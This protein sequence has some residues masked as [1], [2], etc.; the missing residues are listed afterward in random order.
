MKR[1]ASHAFFPIL[2][3]VLAAFSAPHQ[4]MARVGLVEAKLRSEPSGPEFGVLQ[5]GA[6]VEIL[7]TQENW[8][9]VRVTGWVYRPALK[10]AGTP[11]PSR[12]PRPTETPFVPGA[13]VIP[14]ARP[15]SPI[16]PVAPE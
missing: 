12:S 14:T 1:T 9:K 7:E 5:P 4:R 15:F 13:H 16:K 2:A 11:G 6:D 10:D 3:L 8:T